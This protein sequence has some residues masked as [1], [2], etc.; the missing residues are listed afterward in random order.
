MPLNNDNHTNG[1]GKPVEEAELTKQVIQ[2][3]KD[4]HA[5]ISASLYGHGSVRRLFLQMLSDKPGHHRAPYSAELVNLLVNELAYLLAEQLDGKD[6][7]AAFMK[8]A[9]MQFESDADKIQAVEV[10]EDG[11]P[12]DQ[13]REGKA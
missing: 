5:L 1:G 12:A 10:T 6:A 3:R 2:V 4:M 7:A 9:A 13:S 11:K 8:T